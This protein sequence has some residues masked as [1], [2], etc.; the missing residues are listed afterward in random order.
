M[1]SFSL[2][3]LGNRPTEPS[4]HRHLFLLLAALGRVR[5]FLFARRFRRE[6][7][8]LRFEPP[9]GRT[10]SCPLAAWFSRSF[11]SIS[12]LLDYVGPKNLFVAPWLLPCLRARQCFPGLRF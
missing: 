10:G 3:G 2:F 12:R 7:G 1:G 11:F 8:I 9:G 5:I 4:F 6:S